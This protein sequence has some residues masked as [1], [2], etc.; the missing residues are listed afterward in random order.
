MNEKIFCRADMGSGWLYRK[1]GDSV[2]SWGQE[3]VTLE[4]GYE[5]GGCFRSHEASPFSVKTERFESDYEEWTP[6]NPLVPGIAL[7]DRGGW[8]H[9]FLVE[10]AWNDDLRLWL[11]DDQSTH[12]AR[13]FW[14]AKE[15][16]SNFRMAVK[17]T[18]TQVPFRG[19]F[20]H[21]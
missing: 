19:E 6:S 10:R 2:T 17:A 11:L 3:Y 12:A 8:V 13:D 1:A 16:Y 7:A 18:A 14:E 20:K 4:S 15:G 21:S 5:K 9:A